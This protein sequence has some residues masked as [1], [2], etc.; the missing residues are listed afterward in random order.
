M[1]LKEEPQKVIKYRIT[2]VLY[3][4]FINM[5]SNYSYPRIEFIVYDDFN[6]VIKKYYSFMLQNN[7]SN[8][9]LDFL[10]NQFPLWANNRYY[11]IESAT[12]SKRKLYQIEF[13]PTWINKKI[14]LKISFWWNMELGNMSHIGDVH[15]ILNHACIKNDNE[16]TIDTL[17]ASTL[18][19][20]IDSG[21][22]VGF[23]LKVKNI[24]M[25]NNSEVSTDEE[26]GDEYLERIQ[27]EYPKTRSAIVDYLRNQIKIIMWDFPDPKWNK[28]INDSENGYNAFIES[29]EPSAE[30]FG[31]LILELETDD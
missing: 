15:N 6:I 29:S 3:N 19:V 28:L 23:S 14:C 13:M 22:L 5:A 10:K 12:S 30:Q 4:E 20:R 8:D 1:T 9:I 21:V 2:N 31:K 7:I 17:D 11:I 18:R 27:P 25:L 26:D 16:V 24:N